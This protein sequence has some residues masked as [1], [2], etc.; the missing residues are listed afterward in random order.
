ME[1]AIK[2]VGWVAALYGL[3]LVALYIFQA[4]LIYYPGSDTPDPARWGVPEMAPVT[5]ETEDGLR[6]FSWWAAPD[7]VN[8]PVVVYF[9]GNAGHV[10]YRGRL[11]RP[12]L[13]QGF[14]VLLL[15]WRGFGGNPGKPDEAGLH[16]DGRAAI[17]FLEKQGIDIAD[18]VLFGESI[19]SAVAVKLAAEGQGGML[20]IQAPFT[21]LADVAASHYP[22]FPVRWLLKD[23]YESLSLMGEVTIP[24]LVL[25]GERDRIVPVAMGRK[26]LEAAREP[27]AGYFPSQAGHNDLFDFGG[28]QKALE[29]INKNKTI[30]N[31]LN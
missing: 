31:N 5:L 30:I 8:K 2:L 11:V 9:H 29:F 16:A 12:F 7:A 18:R 19:G 27:K 20:I 28:M 22:I 10:G 24:V 25:H 21:S 1:G 26:I 17:R 14:G 4:S 23:K 3:A 15:S 6:L 13:D